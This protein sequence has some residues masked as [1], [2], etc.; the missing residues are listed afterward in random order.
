MKGKLWVVVTAALLLPSGASAQT[1]QPTSQQTSQ[2]DR[3]TQTEPVVKAKST[4]QTK[5]TKGKIRGTV[6]DAS[7]APVASAKVEIPGTSHST[8]SRVDGSY[9]FEGVAPGKHEVKVTA[10]GYIGSTSGVTVQRGQEATIEI[11]VAE[12]PRDIEEM[13]ITASRSKEK[14]LD[15]P[16]TVESVT[17]DELTLK[18]GSTYLTALSQAKGIDFASAGLYDKRI[19]ARGF[20]N[21]F[22]SRMISMLDGRLATLPGSGLPQAGLLP[23]STLDMK[24]VELVIGP[25][26]ALYGPNAHTGVIN[27]LT[28]SPWDESGASITLRGGTQANI[29][30]AA[31]VAGTIYEDFGYKFNAQ[32]LRA[33]DFEPDRN[34]KTHYFGRAGKPL[35]FEADLIDDYDLQSVKADGF[36]YYQLGRWNAKAGYGFSLNDGFS[37]TNPGRNHIRNW[38]VHYQTAQVSH[39]NWFAQFTRTATDAGKTYQLDVLA[40]AAQEMGGAPSDPSQLD[41]IRDKIKFVDKSQLYDTEVQYRNEL[42]GVKLATGIQYRRYMPD[43]GGTY[44]ADAAG[45]DLGVNEIGGYLQL[46][47]EFFQR[48]RLVGAMRVDGHSNYSAQFSPKAAVVYKLVKGHNLRVG[49]NRAFKSPTVLENYLLLPSIAAM[50]NKDGFV[51][52][53][54][55]GKV[56]RTIDPLEPEKVDN[57]ELGYKGIIAR[58]L[59]L[60]AV[61]YHSWYQ[62]FLSP[63]SMQANPADGTVA[64]H[65]DGTVVGKGSATEGML[66]SYNNFGRA[67]VLGFDVGGNYYVTNWLTLGLSTSYIHLLDFKS[68]TA[69][70]DLLLN[71]PGFKLRGSVSVQDLGIKNYFVKLSGRFQSAYEFASGRWVSENFYDDGKVPARFVADISVGYNFLDDFTVTATVMNLFNNHDVDILGA[72]I[73]GTFGFIQLAYNYEGLDY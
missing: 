48:L 63:L 46:D 42:F 61:A 58:R 32:Y 33:N 71:V 68:D 9:L 26:S 54:A 4:V 19:S 13:V 72:P 11:Q 53:D 47:R 16:A 21:Q 40:A 73:Q 35:I 64:Y 18:G 7:G 55:T 6:K 38:Q 20:N 70:S 50:G 3:P 23:T 65:P 44:L 8:T 24:A 37:I 22:N 2:P 25:A 56:V 30:V 62:N 14:I 67:Q 41:A 60:D 39:P 28:K 59:F 15:A 5:E 51:I 27:I 69:Q 31:R 10:E 17:G 29:D 52:K 43:S 12:Q 66:M 1:S 49:Y 36:F 34:L 57:I 45:V